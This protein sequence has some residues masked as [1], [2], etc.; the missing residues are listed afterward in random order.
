MATVLAG[1]IVFM[2]SL[3]LK[4]SGVGYVR[5]SLTVVISLFTQTFRDYRIQAEVNY[6]V[7]K[8]KKVMEI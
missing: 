1:K 6:M 2:C 8:K 5:N 7:P 3:Q 4:F